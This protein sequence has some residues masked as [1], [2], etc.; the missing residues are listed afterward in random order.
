MKHIYRND[1]QSQRQRFRMVQ[2]AKQKILDLQL[3]RALASLDRVDQDAEDR[4]L[5]QR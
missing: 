4:L 2:K 5:K 1:K 3:K